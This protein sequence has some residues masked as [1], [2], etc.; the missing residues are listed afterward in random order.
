MEAARAGMVENQLRGGGIRDTRVLAAMGSVPREL[1]LPP[2]RRDRAYDD[3]ALPIG[4]GQTMSQPWVVAAI[5]EALEL[6]GDEKVLEVG[7]G[8][9]YSAAVLA[10]L[11]D[12][13]LSI[14][15]VEELAERARA[16]LAA[17]GYDNVEVRA[18]DGSVELAGPQTYDAIAVHAAA[19]A[20][21]PALARALRPGGRLVIPIAEGDAD[22]LVVF[23]RTDDGVSP[24]PE[25]T[26]RP[27]APCRF[28]PLLGEGGFAER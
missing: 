6:S 4:C 3:G 10:E 23:H 25:L 8:S 22:M 27:I 11:A 16:T 15:L 14:E 26:R 28:V 24:D 12:R 9:G 19:P 17:L 13:V 7:T 1:F 5:C 18:G 21:P 20:L 2:K